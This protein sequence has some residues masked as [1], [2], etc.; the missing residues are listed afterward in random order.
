MVLS[1]LM[2]TQGTLNKNLALDAHLRA[3]ATFATGD[4][5]T[6]AGAG[7]PSFDQVAAAELGGTT[8]F[9]S[10]A[11]AIGGVTEAHWSY[12]SWSAKDEPVPPYRDPAQLFNDLFASFS[13]QPTDPATPKPRDYGKSV[14]D[15]VKADLSRLQGHLGS[16][17]SSRLDAH[18][19]AVR[20]IER[21][22]VDTS[23]GSGGPDD[24]G[25]TTSCAKP[26]APGTTADLSNER[27]QL[28][29][30]MQVL[31]FAC[32]LTRFGSFQMGS[33][34]DERVF[35]WLGM[36]SGHHT[37]SHDY[38]VQG[39]VLR[40]KCWHDEI[41]QFAALLQAMKD[42]RVSAD[43]T[44]LDQAVVFF[45]SEHGH[46]AQD[47]HYMGDLPVIV[48]GKGGGQLRTG[49]HV[50]FS[51]ADGFTYSDVMLTMLRTV[52]SQA[53]SFGPYGT[54]IVPSLLV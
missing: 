43:Q 36:K 15:F 12:I 44:L 30:N 2:K 17:D 35:S 49:Q 41:V 53:A 42:V 27:M 6:A 47:G 9:R 50:R 1:G 3:T 21:Q 16:E 20:E 54:K 39:E 10:V 13:P 48:A 31:A 38:T 37:L 40:E 18:L 22:V 34:A 14:L 24:P 28:M 45:G 32:D 33:R 7:G 46:A 4:P 5:V 51:D 52:G 19:T 29:L 11:A 25:V 23:T 8:K 26:D